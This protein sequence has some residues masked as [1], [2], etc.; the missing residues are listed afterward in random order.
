MFEILN[1]IIAPGTGIGLDGITAWECISYTGLPGLRPDSLDRVF[2]EAYG[3]SYEPYI[4]HFPD[5]NASIARLLVRS[6]IPRV[7]SAMKALSDS[8]VSQ[9]DRSSRSQADLM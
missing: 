8:L 9:M 3:G 4:F 5:G 7:A 6:L 2:D 1:G